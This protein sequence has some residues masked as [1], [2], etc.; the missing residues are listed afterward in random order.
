MTFSRRSS[1]GLA[2][3][4]FGTSSIR[5]VD[6][7]RGVLHFVAGRGVDG[8]A[9]A[10]DLPLGQGFSGRVIAAAAPIVLDDY[11]STPGVLNPQLGSRA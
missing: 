4:G 5:L 3:A 8:A 6:R 9:L 1:K 2:T 7:D 10:P 11:S